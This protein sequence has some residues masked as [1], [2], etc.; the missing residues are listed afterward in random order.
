M[1]INT[2]FNKELCVSYV[3]DTRIHRTFQTK[4][5]VWTVTTQITAYTDSDNIRKP[6]VCGKKKNKIMEKWD[7]FLHF[8][9]SLGK[10]PAGSHSLKW[11]DEYCLFFWSAGCNKITLFCKVQNPKIACGGIIFSS[12]IY[13]KRSLS[14]LTHS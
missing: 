6:E 4:L 1:Y 8:V 5:L 14:P 7:F 2:V 3:Y 11:Y 9:R 13:N 12:H 10:N